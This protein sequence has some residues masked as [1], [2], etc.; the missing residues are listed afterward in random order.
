MQGRDGADELA[1]LVAF[2]VVVL[3]DVAG[4]AR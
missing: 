4:D 2:V 1:V 3:V